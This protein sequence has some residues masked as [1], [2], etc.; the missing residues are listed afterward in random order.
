MKIAFTGT[1]STGKTTTALHLDSSGGLS[2]LDL[3]L[4]RPPNTRKGLKKKV[5]ELSNDERLNFQRHRFHEKL[6][7]EA[8]AN[9]FLV[10]RS[11]VDL[12]AY[13][14][15]IAPFPDKEEIDQHI[16]MSKDYSLHFF[17]PH[18]VIP[19]EEDGTRPDED[20]S[21]DVSTQIQEIMNAN[22]IPY[23]TLINPSLEARCDIIYAEILKLKNSEKKD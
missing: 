20:Y 4:F 14:Y 5:N 3:Q 16:R 15:L 19:Y 1:S 23:I 8:N 12:L 21:L 18:G 17:F 9:D 11:F 6:N 10:E 2:R 7:L 22:Q 13:R